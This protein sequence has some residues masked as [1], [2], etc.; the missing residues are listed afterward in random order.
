MLKRDRQDDCRVSTHRFQVAPAFWAVDKN[1]A[2]SAIVKAANRDVETLRTVT[3][4]E[5]RAFAAVRQPSPCRPHHFRRPR[6]VCLSWIRRGNVALAY[7]RDSA[8]RF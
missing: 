2:D 7:V 1:L 5:C 8:F 4:I 6:S 3:D